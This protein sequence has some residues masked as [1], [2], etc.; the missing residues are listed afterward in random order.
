MRRKILKLNNQGSTLLTVIICLAF[1]GILGSMMLSVTMT[2]LQMKIVESKS[3]ENF[4]TCEE[5]MEEIRTGIE[6]LA[7]NQ[8]QDVYQNDI[9]TNF[10]SYL[11]ISSEEERNTYIKKKIAAGIISEIGDCTGLSEADLTNGIAVKEKDDNIFNGYLSDNLL[12]G[13]TRTVSIGINSTDTPIYSATG[14]TVVIKD[15][16]VKL[17]KQDYET[18]ITSDIVITLPKFTFE[19]GSETIVYKMDPPFQ[20]Y[21]LVADGNILSDQSSATNTSNTVNGNVYAGNGIT[22]DSNGMQ[23]HVLNIN[24]GNIVTRGNI[25][26]V[27]TGKIVIRGLGLKQPIVWAKNLMTNTSPAFETLTRPTTIDIDGISFIKDDLTLDGNYSAAKIAGAYVGFT[28][29]HTAE[30]SSMMINGAGSS[31]DLSGLDSLILAGRAHVFVDD[32]L[33]DTYI[34]TGE[35]I[36]FKSNQ[37]AYLI[38][39]KFIKDIHHNP[40]TVT[41]VEHFNVPQ[42]DF[43]TIDPAVDMIFTNYVNSAHPFK[44][45]AKQTVELNQDTIL[46]YYYLDFISGKKADEYLQ[47]YMV[48]YPTA[49]NIMKP[50]FLGNVTLPPDSSGVEVKCVGNQ[51]SYNGTA[52]ALRQGLSNSKATDADLDTDMNNILL[53]NPVYNDIYAAGIPTSCT[54]SSLNGLYS[55]ISHLL[56]LDS[57]RAYQEADA[58][59]RSVV[60]PGGVNYIKDHYSADPNVKYYPSSEVIDATDIN[61]ADT[62][63]I[64]VNGDVTLNCNFNGLLVASGDITI[65]GNNVPNFTV[66]GMVVSVGASDGTTGGNITVRNNVTVNGR[67]VAVKNIALGADD[68]FNAVNDA[69]LTAIFDLN[70]EILQNLFKYAEMSVNF[71]IEEPADNLVDLSAL[72]SYENWRKN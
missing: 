32:V 12:S 49:L 34:L 71:V 60:I 21:A 42:V 5:A 6:E 29:V 39:G 14:D 17:T 66:N 31:L 57:T 44:I 33:R 24:A 68:T 30:G 11:A 72:I 40:I 45:A 3:K 63:F 52:V 36:A 18:S 8:I 16:C 53:N 67:L 69:S 2:N 59:V 55:K 64:V 35:S 28:G 1:I 61:P 54:L 47:Q 50:F 58:T 65:N 13:V 15:I 9:M 20:D 10:A 70:G 41:D 37:M 23:T 26:A 19:D 43:S 62:T 7:S 56:Y 4:Y 27:D 51:M 46:R 22:V 38:P 48:K 25:S